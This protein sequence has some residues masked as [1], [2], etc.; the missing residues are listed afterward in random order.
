M[1]HLE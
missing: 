1:Y